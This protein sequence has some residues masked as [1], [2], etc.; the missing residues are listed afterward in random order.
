MKLLIN[1]DD[2]G[3]SETCTQAIMRAFDKKIITTSTMCCNGE[4]FEYAVDMVSDSA[5]KQNIGIHFV[6]TEGVP[7]T[8]AIRKD[9][10]FCDSEGKFHGKMNRY[11]AISG[12]RKELVYKELSAQAE[13]F[14]KVGLVFEHADSH[15]HIHTGPVF[16]PVFSQV[17]KEYNIN[18][19][20]IHRNLGNISMAKKMY[21]KGFN[22]ILI[23]KRRAYTDFFCGFE[24]MDGL[25]VNKVRK[26]SL[27]IMCHP[28]LDSSGVL[29]N[30][31]NSSPYSSPYG[32]DLFLQYNQLTEIIK[33]GC[34]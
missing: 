32:V 21:K 11:M 6:L 5:Y 16:F 2:F 22:S 29:I 23:G 24:D 33:G 28:D 31:D 18:A 34:L 26:S 19:I 27:E 9:T 20:R 14:K 7:L 30:R 3:W 12:A 4:A 1:A 25:D 17:M 13:R 10:Y 15:H 8:D